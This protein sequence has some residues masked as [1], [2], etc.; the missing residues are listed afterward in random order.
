MNTF[1][2]AWGYAVTYL[3]FASVLTSL[4]AVALGARGTRRAWP[5]WILSS[6]LYGLFF[7]QVDL[8]ASALLQLVF[9]AAAN[10]GWFG[11]KATGV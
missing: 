3:E 7:Y 11:W 2:T 10:C 9:L 8:F 5:W 4:I 1:F 6:T